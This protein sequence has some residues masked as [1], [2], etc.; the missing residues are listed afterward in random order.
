MATVYILFSEE[1][2]KYYIGSCKILSERLE[3]HKTKEFSNS[4]T[5]H[6]DDW[7]VYFHIGDLNYDQARKIEVHIKSM[8]SKK[9]IQNLVK[10][11]EI[12]KNLID[13]Y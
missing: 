9:Y 8:K 11:P 13:K 10:Y 3:Q 7:I 6:S 5:S 2:A 4:F 1:L 12:I